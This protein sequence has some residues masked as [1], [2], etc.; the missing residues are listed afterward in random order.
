[1]PSLVDEESINMDKLTQLQDCIEQ[2]LLI[3]KL[4]VV[5]LVQRSDFKQ[6]SPDVPVTRTRPKD[7]V[8]SPIKFE[9][10]YFDV[11]KE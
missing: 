11:H 7:K 9:G 2:L 8:D 1:M 3:M 10:V 5:Q 6:I 4:S